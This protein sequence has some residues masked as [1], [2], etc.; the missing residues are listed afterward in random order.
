MRL[1]VKRAGSV[2][3]EYQFHKGPIYI[4]RH[5]QNHV[6]LADTMASRQHAVIYIT[7][8]GQ[9]IVED[10][11]SANGTS[12]NGKPVDKAQVRPGD[13]IGI[14]DYLI[15]IRPDAVVTG[16]AN[17]DD[18]LIQAPR[19]IQ[20]I[21]RRFASDQGPDIVIPPT[22]LKDLAEVASLICRASGP[23]QTA[24]VVGECIRRQLGAQL[25]WC[26]L[27]MD[28]HGPWTSQALVTEQ[29]IRP[30]LDEPELL[31]LVDLAVEKKDFVLCPKG[32]ESS[33]GRSVM[34][35]PAIDPEGVVGCLLVQSSGGRRPFD[36]R[37]LDYLILL[38]LY[39]A[40]VVANL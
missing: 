24:Q 15:E 35:C 3:Q 31:R 28:R 37:D 39:T 19:R 8:Q 30:K 22:R 32:L 29:G 6:V 16:K 21:G 25:A 2:L 7:Q 33:G 40:A 23:D 38:A 14:A 9:A 27:R 13:V 11:H 26:G 10:L 34:V 18:T 5:A 1:I 4:G 17:L 12:L 36:L 20:V